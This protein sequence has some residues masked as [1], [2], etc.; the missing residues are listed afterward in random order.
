MLSPFLRKHGREALSYATIQDG[1]EYF[2]DDE[3]GYVA[4]TTVT[5]PVFARKPKRIVLSDPVCAREDLGKL[6]DRFLGDGTEATFVVIS[7]F[8]AEE[9][10]A[11]GYKINCLGP[12]RNSRSR[13]TT[14]KETGRSWT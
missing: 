1:M 5:H 13:P 10:R 11:R 14:P 3:L 2:I 12:S 4:F 7:E 8:C 6:L 9:L